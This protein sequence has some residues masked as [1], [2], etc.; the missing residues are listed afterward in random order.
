ML[1]NITLL[2]LG[3][4]LPS[5]A[6]ADHGSVSL[7]VGYAAPIATE[8]G[9]TLPENKFAVGVRTEYIELDSYSDK[10]LQNLRAADENADL[11]SVDSLWTHSVAVSYGLTDDFTIGVRV[12]FIHRNN[13]NEPAHGHHGE[14][15]EEHHDEPAEIER[16]GDVEGIGDTIFHG[17][18]RF[19][20]DDKTDIAV[21]FGIKA[22]TGKTSRH[23]DSGELLET[24]F[25]PGS[26]SWD[27]IGGL[28]LTRRFNDFSFNTSMVYNVSSEGAQ[29]TDL[30]DIFSYNFALAYKLLGKQQASYLP[31]KFG[32]DLVIELNGEHRAHEETNG[33]KDS[34]SGGNLVFFSPGIR[35]TA[36]KIV[37]AGLSVGIPVV[38]DTNGDQVE[39]DYRIIGNVNF[40]F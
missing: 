16:L 39:P 9:T 20:K 32:L 15:E 11:H 5:L 14:E 25:Q 1:K 37:S 3:M 23:S 40:N 30:G 6:L 29:N 7:G 21:L 34:N 27:G 19:F 33:H 13:I 31:P 36:S 10:R 38:K 35:F 2:A 26:G 12:P 8:S 28:A 4:G 22:P 24:E 17:K 18:Y